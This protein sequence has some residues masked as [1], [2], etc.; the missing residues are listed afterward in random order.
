[1]AGKFL[2]GALV[3]FMAT[4]LLPLPN[5]II[6][7]YNPETMTHTWTPAQTAGGT[8]PRRQPAGGQGHAR[9]DRSPSRS[10]WTPTT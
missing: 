10:R 2:R 5:V 3:E 4:F 9:R 1:M 8:G 7:Q 6:F